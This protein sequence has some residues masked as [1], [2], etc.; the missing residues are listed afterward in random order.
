MMVAGGGGERGA[1]P[2]IQ[3]TKQ[4][5]G[6]YLMMRAQ[7]WVTPLCELPSVTS[8]HAR[9]PTEG[10]V[11]FPYRQR[12]WYKRSSPL[13]PPMWLVFLPFACGFIW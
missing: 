9:H 3:N 8:G 11:G 13:D 5:V 1:P 4:D 7:A 2:F 12:R 6:Y 10:I